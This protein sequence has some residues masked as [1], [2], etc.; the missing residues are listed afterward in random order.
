MSLLSFSGSSFENQRSKV[1]RPAIARRSEATLAHIA[2][3]LGSADLTAFCSSALANS[4][5]VDTTPGSIEFD[6]ELKLDGRG[7]LIRPGH[8]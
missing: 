2:S 8:W 6:I 1:D 7:I 3:A 4:W 5:M